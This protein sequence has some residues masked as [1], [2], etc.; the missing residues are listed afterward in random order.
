M[1]QEKYNKLK[2]SLQAINK[3]KIQKNGNQ[4]V[5]SKNKAKDKILH[6]LIDLGDF[7][8]IVNGQLSR[9]YKIKKDENNIWFSFS[10]HNSLQEEVKT[11][12]TQHKEIKKEISKKLVA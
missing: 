11:T 10:V 7:T 12:T 3:I 1:Q 9:F 6:L 2:I 4:E 5:T 8:I